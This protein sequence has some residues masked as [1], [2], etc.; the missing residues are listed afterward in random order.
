MVVS[1]VTQKRNVLSRKVE[2]CEVYVMT[3][4]IMLHTGKNRVSMK[5]STE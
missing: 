1:I 2:N 4:Q 5:N 3:A